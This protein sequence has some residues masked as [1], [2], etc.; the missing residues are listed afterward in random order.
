MGNDDFRELFDELVHDRFLM[1]L[2]GHH[3]CAVRYGMVAAGI[4]D[5][6][7][8]SIYPIVG[9]FFEHSCYPNAVLVTSDRSSIAVTIRPIEK[10]EKV[11]ISYLPDEL[12]LST[13]DR[14]QHLLERYRILC[15]CERCEGTTTVAYNS[16][17]KLSQ[18]SKNDIGNPSNLDPKKAT[19]RRKLTEQC[20][21]YLNSN[22]RDKWC[23]NINLVLHTYMHLLRTKHYLNLQH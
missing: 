23:D 11:T 19:K 8:T 2:I 13:G 10:G 14:R 17:N 15:K 21:E 4:G 20:V 16:K 5:N 9:R 6:D 22:G 3:I 7:G 1:H 18:Q 12:N